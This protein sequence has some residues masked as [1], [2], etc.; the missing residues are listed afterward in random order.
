M[1][2][3]NLIDANK[4][5]DLVKL[6]FY[7]EYL[8]V[9]HLYDE[10]EADYHKKLT[11]DAVE[12]FIDPINLPKESKILDIGCGPGYFMDEMKTRGYTDLVGVTLGP[13]DVKICKEKGHTVK[14]YDISWLPQSDGFEDESTDFIFLRH[15]LEHSPYPIFSLMEYNRI[16]KQNALMYIEVPA[17]D[18]DR[19]HEFN[20]NHY[21]IFGIKQLVAL[22]QRTG[23]EV[24][25]FS[26]LDFD[27]SFP[28]LPELADKLFK[29]KFYILLVKK[30]KSLDIK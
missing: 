12:K 15:A 21:S 4:V 16:L 26:N 2:A 30:T 19:P 7:N 11:A 6:K 24:V 22:L 20:P 17:P 28:S 10:T 27:V 13:E 23:F 5:I 1:E 14:R 25:N 18:C 3:T 8:Y 29:E 9:T